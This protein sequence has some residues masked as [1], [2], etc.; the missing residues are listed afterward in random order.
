MRGVRLGR[1][2]APV[3]TS[4]I[5]S[6]INDGLMKGGG[7]SKGEDVLEGKEGKGREGN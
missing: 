5:C 6:I 1:P 7:E 4:L 2:H 3:P